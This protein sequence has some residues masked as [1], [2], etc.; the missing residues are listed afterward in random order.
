MMHFVEHIL[1]T[2]QHMAV[3][4][5]FERLKIRTRKKM[6]FVFAKSSKRFYVKKKTV[7]KTFPGKQQI[8]KSHGVINI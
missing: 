7:E 5:S 3:V 8:W 4:N 6:R 2:R 1:V